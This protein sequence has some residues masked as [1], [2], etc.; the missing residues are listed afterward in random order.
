MKIARFQK[1][2]GWRQRWRSV[3]E[4]GTLAYFPQ[5]KP[6]VTARVSQTPPA[7]PPSAATA[8]SLLLPAWPEVM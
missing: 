5:V 4:S 6:G 7:G 3:G 2:D 1:K 8:L